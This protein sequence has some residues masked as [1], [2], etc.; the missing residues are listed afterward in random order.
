MIQGQ[1]LFADSIKMLSKKLWVAGKTL[2]KNQIL[3]NLQFAARY[4]LK[5]GKQIIEDNKNDISKVISDQS[6]NILKSLLN[7][8]P[9]SDVKQVLSDT[10]TQL[11]EIINKNKESVN[12]HSKEILNRLLYGEGLKV[13]RNRKR[14]T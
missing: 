13:I 11:S 14:L 2:L 1:G 3:P 6:K 5:S 7:K 8:T 12:E 9:S 4:G 10:K